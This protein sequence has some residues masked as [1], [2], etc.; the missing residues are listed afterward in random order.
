MLQAKS[1]MCKGPEVEPADHPQGIYD[2]TGVSKAERERGGKIREEA[3]P[4]HLS[5]PLVGLWID[6]EYV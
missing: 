2:Q 3:R 1:S 6:S 4:D 5:R